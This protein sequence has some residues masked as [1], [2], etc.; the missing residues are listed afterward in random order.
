MTLNIKTVA[1]LK[2]INVRKE[3]PEEDKVTAIDLKLTGRVGSE[4]IDRLMVPDDEG[5]M[6]PTMAFWD[7]DGDPRFLSMK[8]VGIYREIQNVTANV[9]GLEL[10]GCKVSKFSFRPL[11]DYRAELTFGISTSS[12]PSNTIAV[13]AEQMHEVLSV[14]L[15]T[16]QGDLFTDDAKEA[17][18][19]LDD[20]ARE[21]G[22]TAT[23]ET[24][25]GEVLA[26]F[27]DG[28]D[29]YYDK[30]VAFVR[31]TG[32][33]SISFVQLKFKLGYNRAARLI[34]AMEAAGIVS[35]MQANGLRTVIQ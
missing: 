30:A 5:G 18:G 8:E 31:E 14:H 34:E 20:M 10:T 6:T 23:L 9:E 13:L 22:T 21:D 19:K 28:Q 15:W 33:P 11:E 29:P 35:P 1:Q 17:A 24:G 4:F 32:R 3:G 26:T 16:P 7:Q 2:H 27:G 25:D 12:F